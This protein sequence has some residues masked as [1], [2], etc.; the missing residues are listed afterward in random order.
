MVNFLAALP[1]RRHAGFDDAGWKV[2]WLDFETGCETWRDYVEAAMNFSQRHPA[3]CLTVH[4]SRLVTKAEEV[5][6]EIFEFLDIPSE[7]GPIERTRTKRLNTSFPSP[8]G[9]PITME[10]SDP[11]DD[12]SA[13]ERQTFAR[14]A[15]ETMVRYGLASREELELEEQPRLAHQG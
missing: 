15:G 3:R 8:D 11:W 9:M 5:Y 7:S 4:H 14:I 1:E 10:F 13:E 6:A 2:P 12:W